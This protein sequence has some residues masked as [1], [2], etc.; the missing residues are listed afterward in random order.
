MTIKILYGVLAQNLWF[1]ILEINL[2]LIKYRLI[3][4]I[5]IIQKPIY[6]LSIIIL[7]KRILHRFMEFEK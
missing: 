4:L 6:Y 3:T 1:T 7:I 5:M 2:N